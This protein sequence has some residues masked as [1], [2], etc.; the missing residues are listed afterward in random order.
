MPLRTRSAKRSLEVSLD[1]D[2]SVVATQLQ[3]SSKVKSSTNLQ[4]VPSASPDKE[5]ASDEDSD[6]DNVLYNTDSEGESDTEEVVPVAK[7][8]KTKEKHKLFNPERGAREVK[9]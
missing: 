1:A 5:A 2:F 4:L 8:T 7:S 3:E 9:E 6:D